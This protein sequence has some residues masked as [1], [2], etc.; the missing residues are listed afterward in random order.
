MHFVIIRWWNFG[1]DVNDRV[2]RIFDSYIVMS[3]FIDIYGEEML[4][5]LFFRY[6]YLFTNAKNDVMEGECRHRR[7]QKAIRKQKKLHHYFDHK[8]LSLL[9]V[10]LVLFS[11]RFHIFYSIFMCFFATQKRNYLNS[12][13]RFTWCRAIT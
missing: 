7:K 10:F 8:P 5:F 6:H 11:L 12:L 4:L 1:D 13:L 2:I 9:K 3:L